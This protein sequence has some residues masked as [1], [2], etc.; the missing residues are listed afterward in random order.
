[1]FFRKVLARELEQWQGNNGHV[2]LLQ[3]VHDL[4]IGSSNHRECL[5]ATMSLL[6]FVGLAGCRISV[7][8][9]QIAKD[10]VQYLGYEIV[11]GQRK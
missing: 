6:N 4:L 10:R 2:T 9:A 5:K 8:K 11:Q 3:Y 1:M 7:K